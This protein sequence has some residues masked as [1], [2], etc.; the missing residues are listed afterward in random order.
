ME[1]GRRGKAL[2]KLRAENADEP[3]RRNTNPKE[4]RGRSPKHKYVP[5]TL[6]MLLVLIFI[7]SSLSPARYSPLA[8]ECFLASHRTP[9]TY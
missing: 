5:G 7:F 9:R 6:V 3:L 4:N 8:R 1:R 2:R